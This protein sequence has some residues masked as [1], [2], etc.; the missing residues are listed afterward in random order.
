VTLTGHSDS[1]GSH[2]VCDRISK[3]S[4]LMVKR[5][6]QKSGITVK[7]NVIG[8]GKRE[9]LVLINQWIISKNQIDAFNRRVEIK[10]KY[11]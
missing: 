10:I 8:K 9:P 6:L 4:A 1:K 11:K 7:I 3:K 2:A 5:Y